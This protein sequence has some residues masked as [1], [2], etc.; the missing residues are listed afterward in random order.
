MS[1]CMLVLTSPHPTPARY[2][3]S[4]S[5]INFGGNECDWSTTLRPNY[6]KA[7]P[8][9]APTPTAAGIS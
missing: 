7:A 9:A 6:S 5:S 2:R 1:L 3:L 4:K 8:I